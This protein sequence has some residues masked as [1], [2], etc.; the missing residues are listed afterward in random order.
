M[1]TC[2][3]CKWFEH[4]GTIPQVMYHF[5]GQPHLMDYEK[6]YHC[7]AL[8]IPVRLTSARNEC[9]LFKERS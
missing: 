2:N 3:D 4:T 9:A 7:N 8:S 5:I 1:K 6:I